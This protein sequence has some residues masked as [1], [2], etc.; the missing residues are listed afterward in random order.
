MMRF[1]V[2]LLSGEII[3]IVTENTDSTI[4]N[5]LSNIESTSNLQDRPFSVM[6]KNNI[7]KWSDNNKIST[8][9]SCEKL[10]ILTIIN[11]SKVPTNFDSIDHLINYTNTLNISYSNHSHFN[12]LIEY[13]RE[14]E[15]EYII[16]LITNKEFLIYYISQDWNRIYYLSD[17]ILNDKE[18]IKS[19]ISVEPF[20]LAYA[21]DNVL[22][23]REMVLLCV[24]NNGYLLGYLPEFLQNDREIVLAAVINNGEA[25][26]SASRRL[27][28]DREIVIAAIQN[29]IN[30]L[31]FA[32][33]NL[34][35]DEE[36]KKMINK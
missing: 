18:F 3:C 28:N 30:A 31:D 4:K 14:I 16:P 34:Q 20:I 12:I 9:F 10:I 25:L 6:Y 15:Y 13:Y 17:N 27:R 35:N 21:S 8:I 22:N 7:L 24:K 33:E 26:I 1:E 36:I 2:V 29:N 23:D 5:L 11:F 19:A 32:S